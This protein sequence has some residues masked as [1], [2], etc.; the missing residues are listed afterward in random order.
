ME[1]KEDKISWRGGAWLAS[2]AQ[3]SGALLQLCHGSSLRPPVRV[4]VLRFLPAPSFWGS[5]KCLWRP[6]PPTPVTLSVHGSCP[7]PSLGLGRKRHP[8]RSGQSDPVT[9]RGATAF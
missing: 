1:R 6:H 7:G 8:I 2:W 4:K 3:G 5:A 9:Q